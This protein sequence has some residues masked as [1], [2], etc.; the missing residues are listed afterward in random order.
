MTETVS[1]FMINVK[2]VVKLQIIT[3][4]TVD[5]LFLMLGDCH[6]IHRSDLDYIF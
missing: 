2:Y 1:G 3:V 5:R 6:V 4:D